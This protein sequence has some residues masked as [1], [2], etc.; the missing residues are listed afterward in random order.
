MSEEHIFNGFKIKHSSW[1]DNPRTQM[2]VKI[3]SNKLKDFKSLMKALNRPCT[4]G[5]DCLI[6][7]LDDEEIMQKYLKRLRES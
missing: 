6:A 1:L 5:F 4:L 2:T 3:D 7:L